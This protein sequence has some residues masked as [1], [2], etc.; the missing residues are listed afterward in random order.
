MK[1][2]M[3]KKYRTWNGN[4]VRILCID[5]EGSYP[6]IGMELCAGVWIVGTW[7]SDGSVDETGINNEWD[8]V[9]EQETA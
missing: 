1:I 8:L 9:E 6:V 7:H 5:A 4:K 3:G 2:E